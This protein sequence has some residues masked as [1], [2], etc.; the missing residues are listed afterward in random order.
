M[1]ARQHGLV[2]PCRHMGP[3]PNITATPMQHTPPITRRELL[4][5]H[6]EICS[7]TKSTMK[8]KN[9]DYAGEDG[10]D[11]AFGN[12][13]LCE[14]MGL[15]TLPQGILVRMS[16]KLKRVINLT[17]EDRDASVLDESV[18]DSLEDLINYCILLA[19]ALGRRPEKEPAMP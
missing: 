6:E 11:D 8:V 2:P 18:Q 19:A 14:D 5:L 12:L 15:A 3:S 13:R 16:D 4:A 9:R 10:L 17:Q 7:H 1:R